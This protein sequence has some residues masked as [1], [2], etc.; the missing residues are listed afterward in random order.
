MIKCTCGQLTKNPKFCSKSCAAK[1]NNVLYPKRKAKKHNC[2]ACGIK[3]SKN[4]KTGMCTTCLQKHHI[5]RFGSKTLA[6]CHSTFARHRYQCVRHHAHRIAKLIKM[7][8]QC[9]QCGYTTHVEL[10]HLKPISEF[11]SDST[12]KAIN[13]PGNLVFLCPNHHWE[14]EHN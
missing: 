10:A 3:V 13:D 4:C 9:F 6:E 11:S 7:K 12:L 1:H 14:M 8:R 2:S 5:E